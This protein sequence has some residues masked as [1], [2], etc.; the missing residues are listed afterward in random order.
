[1][2]SWATSDP[3]RISS[4]CF[5]DPV[6]VVVT[7]IR[8]V[9]KDAILFDVRYFAKARAFLPRRMAPPNAVS[10]IRRRLYMPS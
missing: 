3:G 8:I 10:C 2:P 4:T 9:M 5:G 6:H 7:M 1:M